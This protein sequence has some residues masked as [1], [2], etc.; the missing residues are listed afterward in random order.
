M[1][2]GFFFSF[3]SASGRFLS[4]VLIL[5]MSSKLKGPSNDQKA[6][7]ISNPSYATKSPA[8]TAPLK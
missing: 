3:L 4:K 7:Q 6:V 2:L 8:K 5:K 1:G